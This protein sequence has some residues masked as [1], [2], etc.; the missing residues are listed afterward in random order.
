MTRD[1]QLPGFRSG[2]RLLAAL[3][4][5]AGG[6]AGVHDTDMARLFPAIGIPE[7]IDQIPIL[8]A[9]LV[10]AYPHD[11]HA[12]TQ[13]LEYYGGYL[14]ESTGIAGQSTLRKVALATGQVIQKITLP[15]QYFGEGLTIFHGKIYQLTWLSKNGFI[16]DLHSFRQIGEFP[17]ET[18][19]WG[20]THDDKSLIMSDGTNKIR[21]IDPVSF[22][23]TRTLEVYAG[24]EGV[25]NLNE[26]EYV[27]G[28]IFANIW[29]S[30]RIARVDA[31]SGQVLAWI[32]LTSIVAKEQHGEEAVL[33]GIAY[34]KAGDRFF[35]TGKNWSKLFEIKVEGRAR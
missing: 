26:L 32:D 2:S 30:T 19:G 12:F 6:C 24:G 4:L 25:A 31:R 15:R 20:F 3:A 27:K 10:R 18:E 1:P 34:D 33:N 21:Y 35:V 22:A 16:Y 11:P 14:Y 9:K 29:H 23:V 17:Y 13:G 8:S 5:A 28:E 7:K